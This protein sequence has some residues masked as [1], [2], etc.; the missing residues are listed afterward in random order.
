[1]NDPLSFAVAVVALVISAVTAWLTLLK[2][3]TIRMTQPTVLYFGSDGGPPQNE[4]LPVKVYLRS[5]LYATSKRGR[6]IESMYAVVKRDDTS[7]TF[8][9]WVYGEEGLKRGSGLYIPQE[10]VTANHHFLLPFGDTSFQFRAGAHSVG[11]FASLVGDKKPRLLRTMRVN[12]GEEAAA[13]LLNRR[14][15]GLYFDWSADA[16]DYRSHIRTRWRE[17]GDSDLPGMQRSE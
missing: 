5:L 14:D 3:G 2:R 8:N 15:Y 7:Q 12:V 4:V 11:I 6:I 17:N 16:A 1:M 9:V 10:G 13:V